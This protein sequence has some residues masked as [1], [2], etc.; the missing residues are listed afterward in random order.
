[1]CGICGIVGALTPPDRVDDQVLEHRGPDGEG[2]SI[3]RR[4]RAAPAALGHR[5]LSILDTSTSGAQPMAYAGG[6]YWITYNGEI[7]NFRELRAELEAEAFGSSRTAT[8]RC[9]CLLARDG[10]RMLD[11]LNGIFAFA[12]WDTERNELFTARDRLGSSHSITPARRPSF[13]PVRGQVVTRPPVP[14]SSPRSAGRLPELP[15]GQRSRNPVRGMHQIPAG[16]CARCTGGS[17]RRVVGPELRGRPRHPEVL[18]RAGPRHRA[19]AVRRQMVTDVPSG[20][21]QRGLDSGAIVATMLGRPE[22]D[23][24]H[25]GLQRGGPC[26]RDRPRRPSLCPQPQPELGVDNHERS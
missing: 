17:R 12:I 26:R 1:M 7:Y 22:G 5:R 19:G 4:R 20:V 6:R 24:L 25:D 9:C 23:Q 10:E 8:R 14:L 18:G 13:T 15:L 3:R 11:R 2:V 21:P 16:H